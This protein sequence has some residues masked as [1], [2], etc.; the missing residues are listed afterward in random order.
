VLHHLPDPDAGLRALAGVLAPDGV[1]NIMVYGKY[2][3]HG[4]YMMQEAFRRLG[5]KQ[6]AEG[7][8]LIKTTVPKL[9]A[10][11]PVHA[12][13]QRAT[14]L[15]Y[16]AG[17]VDTF[18]HPQDRAYTV[19]Q[20]LDFAR[21]AGLH[22]WDWDDRLNFSLSA[23]VSSDHPLHAWMARLPLEER[24]AVTELLL[25]GGGRQMFYLCHPERAAFHVNFTDADWLDFV[26]SIRHPGLT[27]VREEGKPPRLKRR[28]HE[29]TLGGD[30]F[31]L[32]GAIDGH[33]TI[34]EIIELA[35]SRVEAV[36]EERAHNFFATLQDWGHMLYA[37]P[38]RNRQAAAPSAQA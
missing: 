26:P 25:G 38:S 27:L 10:S 8:E 17:L 33:R 34:R 30:G 37:T 20:V 18:L 7:I 24:W 6:D 22:F 2:L 28:W 14:D 36:N 32:F 12:Y 21:A 9:P 5:V 4:V 13:T 16:D 19:P 11:H 31:A 29:F 35:H 15:S 3:R 23:I 1:M